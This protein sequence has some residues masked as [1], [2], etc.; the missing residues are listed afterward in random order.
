MITDDMLLRILSLLPTKYVPT[1][2]L[3]SKRWQSLWSLVS[4]I[5]FD[6]SKYQNDDAD[7][8][9]F[10][11]S[12]YRTLSL[13]KAPVL[14]TL[15][16]KLSSKCHAVDIGIWTD[17][18]VARRVHKLSVRIR[19]GSGP[20]NLPRSLYTCKTLENLTLERC[21]VSDVL[22]LPSL[23]ILRLSDVDYTFLPRVLSGCPNLEELLVQFVRKEDEGKDN[24]VAGPCLRILRMN[25]TRYGTKGGVYAIEAPCVE[26]LKIVDVV[27]YNSRRIENMPNLVKAHVDI[28]QGV[29]HKFLRALASA[30]RLYLC[31]S[32]VSEVNI[33]LTILNLV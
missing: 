13:N 6:D 27:V 33:D 24:I 32:L 18:A 25:D 15:I 26:H 19:K 20:V 1:T 23:K 8:T 12:V 21:L 28:T 11:Q 9:S 14:H 29:T 7:Y 17:T 31:V 3:V 30:R 16:L 2:S 4:R 22:C 5:E 10:T